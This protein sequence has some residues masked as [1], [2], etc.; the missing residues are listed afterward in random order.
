MNIQ[1]EVAQAGAIEV[2][3]VESVA[4]SSVQA[5]VDVVVRSSEVPRHISEEHAQIVLKEVTEILT[6]MLLIESKVMSLKAQ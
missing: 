3:L 6:D 1:H 2:P 4:H 5:V